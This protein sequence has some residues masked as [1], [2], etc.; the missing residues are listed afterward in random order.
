MYA[1][2]KNGSGRVM[3]IGRYESIEDIQIILSMFD[4]DVVISFEYESDE[5]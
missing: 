5:S 1:T 4:K 3:E 2:D